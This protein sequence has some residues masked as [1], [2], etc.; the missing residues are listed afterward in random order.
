MGQDECGDQHGEHCGCT[1]YKLRDQEEEADDKLNVS[2]HCGLPA[3][4]GGKAGVR[5]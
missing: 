4:R 2:Q 3:K 5:L 1:C